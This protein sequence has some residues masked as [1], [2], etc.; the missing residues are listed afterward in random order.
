MMP[1]TNTPLVSIVTPSYNQ[2]AF[3][4]DTLRSVL[5]QDYPAIE[6]LV[7]DGASTDGSPEILARYAG[8]LAWW[9]SEPDKG[10][11]DA[12]NKGFRRARG[13]IVAWLNSDDVY[14]PGAVRRAVQAFQ[15]HPGVGLVFGDALT[16][17]PLGRP[18]NRLRFG[19]WGLDEWMRFRIICQPAVFLRRSLLEQA[20]WVDPAYH[21]LLDHQLW[22]RMARLAPVCYLGAGAFRPLAAA[23]HHPAAKNLTMA[24]KVGVEIER[25]L[26]WMEAQPDLAPRLAADRRQVYGGAYRLSARYL[27]EGG[28]PGPALRGYLRAL[29]CWPSYTLKHSHR[30]AYALLCLARLSGPL[31]RRRQ[32]SAEQHSRRLAAELAAGLAAPPDLAAWKDWPGI[33][34]EW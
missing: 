34:L 19:D 25:V 3:L 11:A 33:C 12:I 14:F 1:V 30:M 6:Y 26:A 5:Q 23:R 17:D 28:Q 9:V 29:R 2:A 10:Q 7:A 8:R 4:E 15:E 32:Q 16:V 13:E 24:S 18:L 20:G 21:F 27:L 22:L 31:D